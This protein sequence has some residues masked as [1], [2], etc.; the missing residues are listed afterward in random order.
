[1]ERIQLSLSVLSLAFL[2]LPAAKTRQGLRLFWQSQIMMPLVNLKLSL[3]LKFP[4]FTLPLAMD[5]AHVRAI[6]RWSIQGGTFFV[7]IP[8]KGLDYFLPIF[9]L[10]KVPL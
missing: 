7:R 3:L 8:S 9:L 10:F 4:M 1:M 5:F 6:V 2:R